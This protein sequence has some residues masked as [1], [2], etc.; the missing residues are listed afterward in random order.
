MQVTIV[1]LP[2]LAWEKGYV[3]VV[4]VVVVVVLQV[5]NIV[6]IFRINFPSSNSSLNFSF[7]SRRYIYL[8]LLFFAGH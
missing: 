1:S 2:Q 4:V 3:V 5:M 6:N 8:L 7:I